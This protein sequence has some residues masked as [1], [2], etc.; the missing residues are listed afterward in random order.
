MPIINQDE[1]YYINSYNSKDNPGTIDIKYN[2]GYPGTCVRSWN[3]NQYYYIE[4]VHADAFYHFP[5]E[6]IIP[7]DILEKIKN[8]KLMLCLSHSHEAYHYIIEDIYKYVVIDSKIPVEQIL[9]LSNSYDIDIEIDV[10]SKL[11]NLDKIKSEFIS[12]FE[13]VAKCEYMRHP[14]DYAKNTLEFK[15]YSKKYNTFNNRWTTHRACLISL[16]SSFNLIDLG[17]VSY[18]SGNGPSPTQS[19]DYEMLM[20]LYKDYPKYIELFRKNRIKLLTLQNMYLDNSHE[21]VDIHKATYNSV[22]KLVYENV[23]FSVI[24]ETLACKDDGQ[25]HTQPRAISEKTFRSIMHQIPFLLVAKP[26]VLKVLKK[27]GYKT[28]SPFINEDYDNVVDDALRIAM[29]AEETL[30]LVNLKDKQLQNFLE[31]CKPIVEH[32]LKNLISKQ[33]F[34]YPRT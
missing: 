19:Q 34:N 8:K 29:V 9:L 12:V 21:K 1:F 30:R 24:T 16:I 10:V 22:N 32:N 23:Y 17:Y 13:Y 3:D 33:T 28:F 18:K 5:I 14:N 20:R 25:G 27:L 11:Y 26:G 7:N 6:K 4:F 2:R 31:G 15:K